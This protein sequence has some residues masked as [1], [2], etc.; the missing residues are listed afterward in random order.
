MKDK[1]TKC[2]KKAYTASL[3]KRHYKEAF[4][5]NRTG[6]EKRFKIQ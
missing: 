5:K 2:E 6:I 4:E 3:C 1:C